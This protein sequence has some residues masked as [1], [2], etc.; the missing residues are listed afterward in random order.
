MS[1]TTPSASPTPASS[2]IPTVNWGG[3]S[4]QGK[5]SKAG[6][7]LGFGTDRYLIP[8]DVNK[9]VTSLVTQNPKLYSSIRNAVKQAT[10]RTYNDPAL[11]GA[12]ITRTVENLNNAADP[13]AKKVSVEDL[14]RSAAALKISTGTPKENIPTRQ[15]YQTAPETI[16][17]N[18]DTLAM[19][20]LGRS[21][22]EED[23]QA[24]WY[25]NL[26]KNIS[27]MISKGIVTT[28][29]V[30]KNPKTGKKETLV[31]QTPKFSQ[32]QIAATTTQALQAADP[33]ALER[34]KRIDFTSW[35]FSKMGGGQ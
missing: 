26:N 18:I 9:Y 23:K 3:A 31:T 5:D 21:I 14:L 2:G 22:T 1:F 7:K 12:W 34:K 6:V 27:D 4:Q 32:E 19:N 20:V 25:K 35:L 33:E 30:V 17:K 16:A 13:N 10:G 15:V 29:T 11:L 24:D 28:S 8:S